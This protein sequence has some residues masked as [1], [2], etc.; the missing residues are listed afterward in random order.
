MNRIDDITATLRSLDPADHHVDPAS[1]RASADLHT[2]LSTDPSTLGQDASPTR[3]MLARKPRP[4]RRRVALASVMAAVV[5]A[6]I[7]AMPSLNGG[8]R[9]FATWTAAPENLPPQ[10]LQESAADC[11]K[12]Q[13]KG[14]GAGYVDDLNRAQTAVADSRGAWVTVVLAGPDGFSALCI[15]DNSA[16]LFSKGMV[17]SVGIPTDY[18][19]PAPRDVFAT[20][21]G[22]GSMHGQDISLAAGYV[23]SDV[24]RIAYPSK[25]R[26]DIIATVSQGH[27]ALWLPGNELQDASNGG[28]LVE[29][30]YRNG[31]T[32]TRTL[33]LE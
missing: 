13:E 5:A 28:L 4:A 6:A 25:T 21:L 27:F 14:A 9:A 12:S 31:T 2:I 23:G 19:A 7:V 11:R 10:Q 16:G 22:T 33:T 17:G 3:R 29:V 20:D 30:T 8:D 15:T 26:G 1:P 18:Q 24:V 32:S